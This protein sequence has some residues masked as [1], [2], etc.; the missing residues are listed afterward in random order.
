M[1]Y[2]YSHLVARVAI[3]LS[4][5]PRLSLRRLS[6]ELGVSRHT[7][8]RAVHEYHGVSFR[9][10]QTKYLDD[11][12]RRELRNRGDRFIKEVAAAFN[13][14]PSSF[15]RRVRRSVLT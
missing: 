12:V 10:L 4:E 5:D 15:S 9:Q 3:R 13:Y 11:A 6:E 2:D 14:E 8:T 7:I 1:G